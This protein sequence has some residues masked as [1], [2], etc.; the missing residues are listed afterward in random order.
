MSTYVTEVNLLVA[1]LRP[2]SHQDRLVHSFNLSSP[3]F[4][5]VQQFSCNVASIIESLRIQMDRSPAGAC[6]NCK[7]VMS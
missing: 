4:H 6:R 3:S 2:S 1:L 5:L 7:S